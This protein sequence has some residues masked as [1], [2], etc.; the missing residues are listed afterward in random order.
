MNDAESH[1]CRVIECRVIEDLLY[2]NTIKWNR[3]AKQYGN[4]APLCKA[5]VCNVSTSTH[6]ARWWEDGR[7]K[8]RLVCVCLYVLVWICIALLANFFNVD[9]WGL[10][11]NKIIFHK[12]DQRTNKNAFCLKWEGDKKTY[13]FSKIQH[14]WHFEFSLVFTIL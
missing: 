7:K 14:F 4:T 11:I 2:S 13:Y 10:S 3:P 5:C 1:K 9:L 8:G 6:E 12:I